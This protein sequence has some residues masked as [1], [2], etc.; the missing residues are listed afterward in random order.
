MSFRI[1]TGNLHREDLTIYLLKFEEKFS[2]WR[3]DPESDT[4]WPAEISKH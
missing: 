3:Q 4:N 1:P 2:D